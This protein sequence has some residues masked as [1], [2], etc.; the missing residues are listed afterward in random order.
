MVLTIA[1]TSRSNKNFSVPLYSCG[2]T[3]TCAVSCP[4]YLPL[5]PDGTDQPWAKYLAKKKKTSLQPQWLTTANTHFSLWAFGSDMKTL[6]QAVGQIWVCSL[7]LSFWRDSG[8]L[9]HVPLMADCW[10]GRGQAR[11]HKHI[12]CL[13][14]T[15]CSLAK[16]VPWLIPKTMGRLLYCVAKSCHKSCEYKIP[17]QKGK[18]KGKSVQSITCLPFLIVTEW[19]F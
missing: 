10:N 4:K 5:V 9:G 7:Y 19:A 16:A 3:I 12:W 6:L 11:S 15:Q 13:W 1:M 2:T 17:L 14:S 8:Y 18:M